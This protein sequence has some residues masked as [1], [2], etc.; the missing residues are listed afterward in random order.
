MME[1]ACHKARSRHVLVN[2]KRC[3]TLA[4]QPYLAP[5]LKIASMAVPVPTMAPSPFANALAGTV[6]ENANISLSTLAIILP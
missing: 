5:P 4:S 1:N 3:I 6:E 2:L